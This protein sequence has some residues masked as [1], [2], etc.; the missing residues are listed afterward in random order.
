MLVD[1]LFRGVVQAFQPGKT[2]FTEL[3]TSAWLWRHGFN[4]YDSALVTSTAM[5][6]TGSDV[7]IAPVYPPTTLIAVAPFT[8]L[9]WAWTNLLWLCLA[10]AGVGITIVLLVRI[11]DFRLWE[12]NTLLLVTFV[13]A[14]DPIHQA[15]HL[16]NVALLV[17]PLCLGGIHL[18]ERGKDVLAGVL[19]AL[20]ALLKPQLGLWVLLFY[21]SQRR[22]WLVAGGRCLSLRLHCRF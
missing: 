9:P 11:G 13:L 16:G 5:R 6:L 7:F 22:K 1:F 20:A 15:F 10:L 12:S 3:Y 2:D 17:V 19:L 21:L 4:F 14:F 8:F 18:A